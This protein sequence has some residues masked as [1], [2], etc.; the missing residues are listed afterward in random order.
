MLRLWSEKK[1]MGNNKDLSGSS[2]SL[3]DS[4]WNDK[5]QSLEVISDTE[6][7]WFVYRDVDY[8]GLAM[9]PFFPGTKLSNVAKIYSSVQRFTNINDVVTHAKNLGSN[10]IT[11]GIV[12]AA[13]DY[14]QYLKQNDNS[15][16]PP[17]EITDL[18]NDTPSPDSPTI[19]GFD[20]VKILVGL[21]VAA[22][23]LLI[24]F[25]VMKSGGVS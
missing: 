22:I 24:V 20:L 2:R 17:V 19:F 8:M 10:L 13:V 9:G 18:D 14:N 11:P 3:V 21:A 15:Y 23:I 6:E 25:K 12:Q 5:A 16:S 4:G 1:L 7:Y